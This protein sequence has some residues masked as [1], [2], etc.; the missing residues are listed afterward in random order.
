MG[1]CY[2]LLLARSYKYSKHRSYMYGYCTTI[3]GKKCFACTFH[4]ILIS[5]PT[6]K[7]I[8]IFNLLWPLDIHSPLQKKI[9]FTW[10]KEILYKPDCSVV[11]YIIDFRNM[12]GFIVFNYGKCTVYTNHFNNLNCVFMVTSLKC[13]IW[14]FLQKFS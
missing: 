4:I 14:W 9:N 8:V 3:S 10:N 13:L 1:V 11:S 12:D 7:E 2:F 6:G 5:S